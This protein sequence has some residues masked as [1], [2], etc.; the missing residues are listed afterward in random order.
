MFF[1]TIVKYIFNNNDFAIYSDKYG[2]IMT[3]IWSILESEGSNWQQLFKVHL[4]VFY[5]WMI[6]LI[7]R[8]TK[9]YTVSRFA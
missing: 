6:K 1:A 7:M 3:T 2:I 8:T 9:T 4:F 5:I